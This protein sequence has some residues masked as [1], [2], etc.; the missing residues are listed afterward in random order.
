MAEAGQQ[1]RHTIP[2][3]V[4]T[5]LF[6]MW[7]FTTCMN[8]IL[9]PYLKGVFDLTHT[10]AMFVQFAFFGAYFVGSLAYFLV[11]EEGSDPVIADVLGL[12]KAQIEGV[13]DPNASLI[14]EESS[15]DGIRKLAE[16]ILRSKGIDPASIV[17]RPF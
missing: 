7:G 3:A 9:I 16:T 6:F 4:L 2:F 5:G 8:D 11:S 10:E 17:L 15:H 12:K 1:Q 14:E 13:R